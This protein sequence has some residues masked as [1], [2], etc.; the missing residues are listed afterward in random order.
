MPGQKGGVWLFAVAR[1]RPVAFG[2]RGLLH[3]VP[4]ET[5]LRLYRQGFLSFLFVRHS[6]ASQPCYPKPTDVMCRRDDEES[7]LPTISTDGFRRNFLNGEV[8]AAGHRAM[9]DAERLMHKQRF[10]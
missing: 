2:K 3:L 6:P 7:S 4:N 5:R 9:E 1:R 10:P 8:N